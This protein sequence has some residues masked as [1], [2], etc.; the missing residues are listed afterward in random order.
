MILRCESL[1]S[2]IKK[3][4]CG[5]AVLSLFLLTI[6]GAI[7]IR[8]HRLYAY[9]GGENGYTVRFTACADYDE[10]MAAKHPDISI[11][12]DEDAPVFPMA[13]FV[14]E[15]CSPVPLDPDADAVSVSLLRRNGSNVRK[16]ALLNQ[17]ALQGDGLYHCPFILMDT[18]NDADYVRATVLMDDTAVADFSLSRTAI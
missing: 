4:I 7:Y 9:Q 11:I 17:F 1:M 6:L 18:P 2:V 10:F 15:M 13:Y 12:A 5:G 3:R 8:G 14:G 16:P